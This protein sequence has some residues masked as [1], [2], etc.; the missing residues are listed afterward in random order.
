M[1]LPFPEQAAEAV[2]PPKGM[3]AGRFENRDRLYRKT[4]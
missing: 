4:D 1:N 2:R 3:D